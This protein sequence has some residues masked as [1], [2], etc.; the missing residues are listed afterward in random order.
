MDSYNFWLNFA[1]IRAY[2][3]YEHQL[4]M[5]NIPPNLFTENL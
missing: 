2:K 5:H 3:I 1:I 4:I